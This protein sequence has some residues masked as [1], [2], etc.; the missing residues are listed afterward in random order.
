MIPM[1]GFEIAASIPKG[2]NIQFVGD[3]A[4]IAIHPEHPPRFTK[5]S[6]L[7]KDFNNWE[8]VLL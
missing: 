4:V 2:W 8:D 5:L 7:P 6:E 1:Y 3:I